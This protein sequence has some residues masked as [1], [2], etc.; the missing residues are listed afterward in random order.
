VRRQR[1]GESVDAA[2]R[3]RVV[4]QMVAAEDPVTDPVLMIV[5]PSPIFGTAACAM[6][7]YP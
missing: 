7:K 2:L 3:H 1:S 4:E 5:P 6:K